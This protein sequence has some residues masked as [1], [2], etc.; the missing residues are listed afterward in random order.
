[1]LLPWV[2]ATATT[3]ESLTAASASSGAEPEGPAR[4]RPAR[5]ISNRGEI[6]TV[7]TSTMFS[8]DWARSRGRRRH[9]PIQR[10]KIPRSETAHGHAG[11]RISAAIA[12]IPAP[13]MPMKCTRPSASIAWRSGNGG[14]GC[15]RPSQD[16]SVQSLVLSRLQ[17]CFGHNASRVTGY[18]VYRLRPPMRSSSSGFAISSE[19]HGKT[20]HR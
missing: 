11:L 10:P 12:L 15:R 5:V 1:M 3:C 17:Y 18:Q 4:A 19:S 9:A 14:S 6:T 16:S 20:T 8:A 2:P 7:S 13:P